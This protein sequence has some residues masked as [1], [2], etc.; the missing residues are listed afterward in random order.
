MF[1]HVKRVTFGALRALHFLGHLV[2]LL[3]E[4]D[5]GVLINEKVGTLEVAGQVKDTCW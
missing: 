4:R 1:L 5:A 3:P 2:S